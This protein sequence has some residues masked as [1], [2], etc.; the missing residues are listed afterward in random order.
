MSLIVRSA[1]AQM[2]G[3][4]TGRKIKGASMSLAPLGF[5][6]E[7]PLNSGCSRAQLQKDD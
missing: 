1:N 3:Y 2:S 4:K 5:F 7:I 6:A